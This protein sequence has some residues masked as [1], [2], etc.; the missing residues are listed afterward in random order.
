V[1]LQIVWVENQTAELFIRYVNGSIPKGSREHI[2][3]IYQFNTSKSLDCVVVMIKFEEGWVSRT[4]QLGQLAE[5]DV[6]SWGALPMLVSTPNRFDY[7]LNIKIE[8]GINSSHHQI[9]NKVFWPNISDHLAFGETDWWTV[10]QRPV[11]SD[12]FDNMNMTFC[13]QRKTSHTNEYGTGTWG[14]PI[15]HYMIWNHTRYGGFIWHTFLD[16]YQWSADHIISDYYLYSDTRFFTHEYEIEF[17][18]MVNS[19]GFG[20]ELEFGYLEPPTDSKIPGYRGF[21]IITLC[22]LIAIVL[23]LRRNLSIKQ[24]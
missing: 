11:N 12:L 3:E 7:L 4:F 10:S 17:G 1:A 14:D 13:T 18:G 5:Y 9:T 23:Y 21:F 6:K 22:A 20:I 19:N 2:S 8:D 16:D 15:R 24:K